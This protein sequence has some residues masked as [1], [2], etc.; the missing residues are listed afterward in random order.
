MYQSS[1]YLFIKDA[2]GSLQLY[3]DLG[4][5]YTKGDIIP[6]GIVGYINI[7]EGTPQ[8]LPVGKS[9]KIAGEKESVTPKSVKISDFNE[10]IVNEY[11]I[12]WNWDLTIKKSGNSFVYT[13]SEGNNTLPVFNRFNSVVFPTEEGKYDVEGFVNVFRGTMQ[14]YPTLFS[15]ASGIEGIG[16]V[17]DVFSVDGGIIIRSESS[18]EVSVYAITGQKIKDLL[19]P[20]GEN[21]IEIQDGIYIISV[22]NKR[23]KMLVR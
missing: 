3:G 15:K 13:L 18:V 8:M 22:G 12:G 16:S 4:K 2:T 7:Y 10:S 6:S 19:V 23:Y 5:T 14:I 1:K 9:F 17:S 20:E 21:L 11:V